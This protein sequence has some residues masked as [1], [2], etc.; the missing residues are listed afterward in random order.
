MPWILAGCLVP[1]PEKFPEP[2]ST[3]PVL[4]VPGATPVVT[5]IVRPKP[6]TFTER[7]EVPYQ[8]QDDVG[9][10]PVA[11]LYM[12]FHTS[13]QRSLGADTLDDP[14][15]KTFRIDVNFG[16]IQ[17]VVAES[18]TACCHQVTMLATHRSKLVTDSGIEQVDPNVSG[19]DLAML[20]WWV[21]ITSQLGTSPQKLGNC[22]TA[23]T[24]S[25]P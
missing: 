11:Y 25:S 24:P 5:Q 14:F 17:C 8:A 18:D 4:N 7:F 13:Q 15:D 6:P 23:T 3:A 10:W 22:P 9:D 20:V 1:D 19:D 2:K 16:D 12:D 21:G